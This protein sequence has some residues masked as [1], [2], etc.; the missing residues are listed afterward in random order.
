[1]DKYLHPTLHDGCNYSSIL[2]LKLTYGYEMGPRRY[3]LLMAER[4]EKFNSSPLDKMAAISQTV[5]SDAFS[6]MK[7]F[8]FIKIEISLKLVL[9]VQLTITQHWFR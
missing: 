2:R 8:F 3:A 9:R 6:W 1:M 5:L 4:F 7:S